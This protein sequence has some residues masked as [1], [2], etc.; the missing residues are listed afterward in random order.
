MGFVMVF[1]FMVSDLSEVIKDAENPLTAPEVKSYMLMLLRGVAYMHKRQVMHRDL[2]PANLLISA[3]GR[4]KIA[5]FG[6]SRICVP[7]DS[8]QYSHQVATRWYRAP[9]LL[10]GAR[11]YNEGVDLW[12]VGCILGELLNNCPLF[13]GENDIDQLGIVI[14][15]LGT[16]TEQSW[17]GVGGLPDYSKITFPDT[18]GVAY[19]D[20]VPDATPGAVHLLSN[21]VIY[22]SAN[23]LAA[24]VALRHHYFYE[25]PFPARWGE[26]QGKP[27]PLSFPS[28]WTRCDRQAPSGWADRARN[29]RQTSPSTGTSTLSCPW[30]TDMSTRHFWDSWPWPVQWP[31]QELDPGLRPS[32]PKLSRPHNTPTRW[33]L[34][35]SHF[36]SP[37]LCWKCCKYV[38]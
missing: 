32:Y 18:A 12:A 2:K 3:E 11:D 9:E 37:G 26:H 14:K 19:T 20:M 22:N 24:S 35:L 31:G 30:W 5:D 4:L 8:R 38:K 21:L 29:T 33:T 23:R 6:L 25:Q 7:G 28:G 16:P 1:E 34:S 36:Q 27:P 13:P 17:P 15:N 10:Y